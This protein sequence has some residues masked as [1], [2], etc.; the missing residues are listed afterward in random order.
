MNHLQKLAALMIGV[1]FISAPAYGETYRIMITND[2]G[3]N[4]PGLVALAESLS[5]KYEVI[6]SAPAKNMS[7]NSH[8]TNLFKGPV[9]IDEIPDNGKYISFAVHGT[10]ADAARFGLIQMR[11]QGKTIDLVISGINPGSNIGSLS[12]LSG[13][14]GA[15][16]EAQYYDTPAIALNLDR[17]AIKEGGYAPA[18]DLVAKLITKVRQEG[19]PKGVI[20]NVNI[21]HQ[22]KG[23]K[24]VPMGPSILEVK[25]YRKAEDGFTA[26]VIFPVVAEGLTANDAEAYK[27]GYT[28]VTPLKIDWTAFEMLPKLK[29]WALE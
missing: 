3:I 13:T 29:D 24:I 7:G 8:A 1:W 27:N 11:N 19:L 25:S 2:D 21:P 12:H 18:I 4:N 26:E 23:L 15:A 22:S 20:L 10:P 17:K 28:T 9:T 14:I 5:E 6:V 16:M